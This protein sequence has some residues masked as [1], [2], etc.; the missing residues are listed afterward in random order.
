MK[1]EKFFEYCFRGL[2]LLF[3]PIIIYRLIFLPNYKL[4]YIMIVPYSILAILY[5]IIIG[6]IIVYYRISTLISF[7]L[8]LASLMLY[9]TNLT[10]MMLKLLS[11]IIYFYIS[12][13]SVYTYHLE[14]CVVG[15]ISSVLI[16][17][18]AI[19]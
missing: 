6:N 3:W 12:S 19:L 11:V 10:L 14:E 9:P 15:I 8:T 17:A 16:F 2:T 13:K 1:R 4:E 18:I 7:I 5:I